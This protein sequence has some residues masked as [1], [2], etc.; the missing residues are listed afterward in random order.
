MSE[1]IDIDKY[2]S[3][4]TI[5]SGSN[6]SK[7]VRNHLDDQG[8]PDGGKE[9]EHWDGR[10]DAHIVVKPVKGASGIRK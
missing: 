9:I 2:R 3:I 8:R 1:V 5:R 6:R 7:Q 4:G 10:Q